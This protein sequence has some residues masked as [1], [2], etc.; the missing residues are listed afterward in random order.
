VGIAPE[1]ARSAAARR[2][3][4]PRAR[5]L[6]PAEWSPDSRSLVLL[7]GNPFAPTTALA[8]DFAT[9]DSWQLA[10][11][12]APGGV[13]FSADSGVVAV[14]GTRRDRIAGLLPAAIGAVFAPI[15]SRLER[16]GGL[17][18]ETFLRI[19]PSAGPLRE[20]SVPGVEQWGAAT[21]LSLSPD[22]VTLYLAQRSAS[23]GRERLVEI[24]RDCH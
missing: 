16:S 1:C 6:A 2:R 9:E 12:V 14:A 23:D 11:D 21:G 24:R 13:A 7:R 19:G 10:D 18:R 5:R 15:A 4:A 22:G 3:V 17:H 20:L 8:V